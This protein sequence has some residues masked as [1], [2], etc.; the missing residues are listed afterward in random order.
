MT[1]PRTVAVALAVAVL[2]VTVLAVVLLATGLGTGDPDAAGRPR[3]V[4]SVEDLT[5]V[6]VS[7]D[8]DDAPAAL[9]EPVELE[10]VGGRLSVR[11]GCN[12]GSGEVEV[13]DSRLVVRAPGLAVTEMGCPDP[14]LTEQEQW[15][16]T[17]VTTRPRLESDGT[18]LTA[19]W[20]QREKYALVLERQEPAAP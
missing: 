1:R 12:T 5:G 13:D 20:G 14:A 8:D 18:R 19:H 10:V 17:L 3:P 4:T 2:V 16:L 11:T 9:V 15:V 6:W 7:V